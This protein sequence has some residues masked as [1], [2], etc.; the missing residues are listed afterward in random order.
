MKWINMANPRNIIIIL[1]STEYAGTLNLPLSAE[2]TMV[3]DFKQSAYVINSPLREDLASEF[4]AG[5]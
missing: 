3:S 2:K 5:R 4:P 1:T